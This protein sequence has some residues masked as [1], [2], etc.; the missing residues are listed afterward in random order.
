IPENLKNLNETDDSSYS[1]CK[2]DF[3]YLARPTP[4]GG[5]FFATGDYFTAKGYYALESGLNKTAAINNIYLPTVD[6]TGKAKRS[7]VLNFPTIDS[8]NFIAQ[9]EY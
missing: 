1:Q 8:S 2:F 5:S 7:V 9:N 3:S 4:M 6:T